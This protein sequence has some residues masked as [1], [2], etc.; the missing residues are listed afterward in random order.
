MDFDFAKI[1]ALTGLLVA[2]MDGQE[3]DREAARRLATDIR[4]EYPAIRE[5]MD[6]V[7]VRLQEKRH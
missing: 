3:F 4:A 2:E 7:L 1:D 6:L 5:T